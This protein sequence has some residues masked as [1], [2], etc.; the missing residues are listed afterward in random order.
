[1]NLLIATME[2]A[3]RHIFGSVGH[4]K[5]YPTIRLLVKPGSATAV[6]TRDSLRE[7]KFNLLV[8]RLNSVTSVADVAADLNAKV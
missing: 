4:Y 8:G 1:M 2:S 6:P 7:P 3:D 5:T